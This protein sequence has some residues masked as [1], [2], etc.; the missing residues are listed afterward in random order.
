M[1]QAPKTLEA[2]KKHLERGNCLWIPSRD[3]WKEAQTM[4]EPTKARPDLLRK[5]SLS[6]S[7][8]WAS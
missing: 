3:D 8:K 1:P 7:V 6:A 5:C 2:K 4:G